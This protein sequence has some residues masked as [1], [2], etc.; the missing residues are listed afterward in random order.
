MKVLIISHNPISTYN[1]MGK[2]FFSLFHCFSKEELCQLYIYPSLPDT[3]KC[4]SYFR[5]TD[6]DVLKS[7]FGKF[8]IGREISSQEIQNAPQRLFV[9]EKDEGLY[10]NPKNNR[11]YRRLARDIMWSCS[12][13]YNKNLK[14]WLSKEQPTC[15]FV[16]PGTGKFLYN[17]AL[18]ISKKYRIPIVAYECDDYYFVQNEKG[19]LGKKYSLELKK[20]I[21]KLFSHTSSIV[22]IS[23]EISDTYS[24]EFG[25]TC[26]TLMTGS[27]YPIS[28][29]IKNQD[30][31]KV[32]TYMGNIRINRFCSLADIGE[33]L[34]E[35]NAELGTN[36]ELH[37]YTAEK[38]TEILGTLEKFSS[39]K[40]QG[41]VSGEKFDEVFHSASMLLHVEA[42]DEQ[43]ISRVKYSVSTKIA[44]SLGSGICLF[45]YGPSS[46]SSMK[47]LIDNDCA[48]CA[49]AKDDLKQKLL[50]AFNDKTLREEKSTQALEVARKYHN[51]DTTSRRLYEIMQKESSTPSNDN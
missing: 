28:Q 34:D 43:S 51:Q 18:K 20:K 39:I 33:K 48:I 24:Q 49:T 46:V 3:D 42:F 10:R 37:I 5:I 50:L 6:K 2:T 7:Y 29:N 23:K 11:P 9:D 31:V 26:N 44:D 13:W 30:D 35:I 36:Y 40:L 27:N 21:K 12:H 41:F 8:N 32:I 17:I 1:N 38:N 22:A 15:I 47:H 45:A 25:L 4:A 14:E 19:L 16:S